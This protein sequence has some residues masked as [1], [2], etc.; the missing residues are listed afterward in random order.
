MNSQR[1]KVKKSKT[2]KLTKRAKKNKVLKN[3]EEVKIRYNGFK[4]Y[5]FVMKIKIKLIKTTQILKLN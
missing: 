5:Y 1:R 4:I 2:Y 3:K